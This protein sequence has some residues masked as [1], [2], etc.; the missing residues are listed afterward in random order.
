MN[1]NLKNSM[2]SPLMDLY[3]IQR[4]ET[5]GFMARSLVIA[6]MPHSKP[7]EN[8]FQRSNGFY[9]LRMIAP[10]DIGLCYG[11]APRIAL[12]IICS[13]AIKKGNKTVYLG[14]S[15]SE[16]MRRAQYGKS[17]G[18]TGTF[19]N[20]R[21]QLRRLLNSTVSLHYQSTGQ[22]MDLR[23]MISS[24]AI[25]FWDSNTN[26]PQ[27]DWESEI[28]LTEE[29]FKEVTQHPVPIDLNALQTLKSS[30]LAIDIYMW[31]TWRVFSL[32]K[33][34]E[35]SWHQ[36]SLQFGSNFKCIQEFRKSFI[37]QLKKV[38]NIYPVCIALTHGGIKIGPSQTHIH[39]NL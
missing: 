36:L 18:T 24:K 20:M 37:H 11:P 30:S 21:N 32:T 2:E 4:K 8:E 29:F 38:L 31:L 27:S 33:P 1:T 3:D 9:T 7:I 6:T 13:E 22:K 39:K 14:S 34:V 17:G 23:F 19:P 5:R 15:F 28:T 16:F 26:K 10:K 35:I 25:Y 12:A